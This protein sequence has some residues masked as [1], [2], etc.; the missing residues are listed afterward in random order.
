M[1]VHKKKHQL[2]EGRKKKYNLMNEIF[3]YYIHTYVR[4]LLF[5]LWKMPDGYIMA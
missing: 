2:N 1:F 3:I 5:R 4:L